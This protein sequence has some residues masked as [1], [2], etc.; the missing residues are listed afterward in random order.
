L[1]SDAGHRREIPRKKELSITFKVFEQVPQLVA[2]VWRG[3]DE[4]R[5]P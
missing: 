1:D 4:I 3:S 2:T 5:N